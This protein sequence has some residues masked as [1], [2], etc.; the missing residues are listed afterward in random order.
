MAGTDVKTLE[1]LYAS[2]NS[3]GRRRLMCGIVQDDRCEQTQRID[4]NR[5]D[6]ALGPMFKRICLIRHIAIQTTENSGAVGFAS[7]MER[8][9]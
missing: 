6:Q 5:P 1:A 4:L 3:A 9:A 7:R 8:I 2:L